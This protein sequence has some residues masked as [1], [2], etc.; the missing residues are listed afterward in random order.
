MFGVEFV[1]ESEAP[2][3]DLLPQVNLMI[4]HFPFY[5]LIRKT[6]SFLWIKSVVTLRLRLQQLAYFRIHYR[7]FMLLKDKPL[8]PPSPNQTHTHTHRTL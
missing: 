5:S 4:E 1:F 7:C 8:Q 3:I 6:T 2:S